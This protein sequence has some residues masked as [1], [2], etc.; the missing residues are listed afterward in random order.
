MPLR[1]PPPNIIEQDPYEPVA[2]RYSLHLQHALAATTP[3]VY[4]EFKPRYVNALR[5]LIAREQANSVIYEV[6]IQSMYLR[7]LLQGPNK[8][9]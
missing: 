1:H 4:A 3:R 8:S 2:H 7:Q 5:H 9:I 6:T